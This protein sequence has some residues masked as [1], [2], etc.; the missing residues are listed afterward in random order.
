MSRMMEQTDEFV[1]AK[2]WISD[3]SRVRPGTSHPPMRWRDP[4]K[5]SATNIAGAA[6]WPGKPDRAARAASTP[7][8]ASS[9]PSRGAYRLPPPPPADAG[10]WIAPAQLADLCEKFDTLASQLSA[11]APD[12]PPGAPVQPPGAGGHDELERL[13][14]AFTREREART[15]AEARASAHAQ[16]AEALE[17]RATRARHA[18]E[19][20]AFL[21]AELE[22]VHVQLGENESALRAA[23]LEIDRNASTISQLP[24]LRA[25]LAREHRARVL[26]EEQVR[27][28]RLAR[29]GF[30]PKCVSERGPRTAARSAHA[31]CATAAVRRSGRTRSRHGSPRSNRSP[32]ATRCGTGRGGARVITS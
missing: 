26:A 31:I 7:T 29:V 8:R 27:A 1:R 11:A 17:E 28:P 16:R 13:H 24:A 9:S 18:D 20:V 10:A 6:R 25:E 2:H 12:P 15:A 19:R 3:I 23:R 14:Y 32:N 30:C 4:A 21:E 22:A 5:V